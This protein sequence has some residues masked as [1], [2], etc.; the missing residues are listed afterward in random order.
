[1]TFTCDECKG[2]HVLTGQV[3]VD[4][5]VVPHAWVEVVVEMFCKHVLLRPE[6]EPTGEAAM[7]EPD[8]L[9]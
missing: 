5:V 9:P 7:V 4:G 8:P 3:L 6:P 1:M 2:E